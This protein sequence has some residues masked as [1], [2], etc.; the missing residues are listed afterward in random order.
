VAPKAVVW[1]RHA[2]QDLLNSLSYLVHEVLAPAAA[3][4]LLD[5]LEAA[6]S[7]LATLPDRGRIVPE[8]GLPR[9]EILVGRYRMVYRV[10]EEVEILRLIHTRQDFARAWRKVPPP[11]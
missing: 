6:A 2:R 5:E 4:R 7:S 1:T 10:R 9:R 8:L 3:A 11:R